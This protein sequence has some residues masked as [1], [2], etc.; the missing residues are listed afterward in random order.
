MIP[1]WTHESV[2]LNI[3]NDGS[4]EVGKLVKAVVLTKMEEMVGGKLSITDLFF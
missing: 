1:D 4:L 3:K 2:Q